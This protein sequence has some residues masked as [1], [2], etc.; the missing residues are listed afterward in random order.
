MLPQRA[1]CNDGNVL[2][3]CCPIWAPMSTEH[4]KCGSCN[5]STELWFYGILINFKLQSHMWQGATIL[6]SIALDSY[7]QLPL[8]ISTRVFPWHFRRNV[9]PRDFDY[10]TPNLGLHP[11]IHFP[12][13]K[14]PSYSS[15]LGIILNSFSYS[16]RLVHQQVVVVLPPRHFQF[17]DTSSVSIAAQSRQ[18][19]SVIWTIA[20]SS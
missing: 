9:A 6:E 17:L 4:L 18:P 5:W 7:I 12:Y 14:P 15:H 2:D 19:P 16:Q 1:F 13:I 3:L 8:K 20:M 11:S 10:P